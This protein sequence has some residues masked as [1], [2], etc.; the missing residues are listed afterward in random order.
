MQTGILLAAAEG[1]VLEG[2]KQSAHDVGQKFG[3][4]TQLFISQMIG[5]FIVAT[6]L[7]KFAYQPLLKILSEREHKIA[8]SL[9][10]AERA[11]A[12]L[13]K[14]DEERRRVLAEA[15]Q[16][17]SRI[18]EEARLAAAKISEQ[19][20]QKA[21]AAANEI[22]AKA[23][24]ANDSELTRMKGELRKEF[25]RLVVAAAGKAS[26]KVLNSDDQRRLADEANHQ[27]A[28]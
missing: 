6:V 2:L 20:A 9:A 3:F 13:A 22:I 1:G 21:V 8:E 25:G 14:A 28:A 11:K 26:G 18:I 7:Y 19:E 27:L 16:Q 10:A 4:N 24:I 23:R 5:F 15:G 17:A 12:D